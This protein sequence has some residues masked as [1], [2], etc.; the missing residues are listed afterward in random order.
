MSSAT[1]AGEV[2]Q[3]EADPEVL[4]SAALSRGAKARKEL[5]NLI[6]A[7][8]TSE[9]FQEMALGLVNQ[10]WEAAIEVAEANGCSLACD[11]PEEG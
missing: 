1:S 6:H 5:D 11:P 10:L 7:S 4:T 8:P 2:E 3:D 9:A